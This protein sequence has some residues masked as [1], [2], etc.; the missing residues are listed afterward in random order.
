MGRTGAAAPRKREARFLAEGQKPGGG[1]RL[2]LEGRGKLT[3]TGIRR[4]DFFSDEQVAAQTD[5]G[6]L[7][8]R[9]EGLHIEALSA[10]TGD[11]LVTGK[12]A[13]VSYSEG[14]QALSL[15]GRLFR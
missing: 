1:H 15:L 10:D 11:M 8:I 9:G 13:A 14:G 4:V 12:V 5:L 3:A 7:N 2:T 6:Q